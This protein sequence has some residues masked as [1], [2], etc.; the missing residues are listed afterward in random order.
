MALIALIILFNILF[1][2]SMEDNCNYVTILRRVVMNS[3]FFVFMYF[4]T[5]QSSPVF[6]AKIGGIALLQGVL[7]GFIGA[8]SQALFI[9]FLT[10]MDDIKLSMNAA[11]STIPLLMVGPAM[12]TGG[13]AIFYQHSYDP[14]GVVVV[15]ALT[16]V[17]T[18][19]IVPQVVRRLISPSF[20]IHSALIF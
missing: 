16:L 14:L 2:G 19:K 15:F 10:G 18:W 20:A 13:S 6:V 12:V 8:G 9:F 17:V 11:A 1:S 7:F 4:Y 5:D 3:L